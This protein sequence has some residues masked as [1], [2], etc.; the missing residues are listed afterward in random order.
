MSI[1][2]WPN[3]QTTA[4]RRT[5]GA[6]HLHGHRDEGN[7]PHTGNYQVRD[8]VLIKQDQNAK[9]ET[10]PYKGPYVITEVR[11]NGTVRVREKNVLDKSRKR[12]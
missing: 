9:F 6:D 10:D 3:H 5:A 4:V 1:R 11:N 8:E 2:R 7:H 12:Y